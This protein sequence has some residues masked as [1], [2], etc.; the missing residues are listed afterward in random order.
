M[1]LPIGIDDFKKLVQEHYLFADKSLFIKEVIEDGAGCG[2]QMEL[3]HENIN[4]H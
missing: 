3:V 1:K 4:T 2:K